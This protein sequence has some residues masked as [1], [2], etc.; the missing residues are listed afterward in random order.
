MGKTFSTGLLTNGIWQDASNNIGIGAAP[1]GTYKLEVTGT[2][3][4]SSTLLVSGA[5]TFSSSVNLGAIANSGDTSLLNIKQSSTAYN[6]GIYLERGGERNG[7]FMYI[8]G[9]VDSLTFRRNYFG[10]QSDVMSLTRDGN[11]G[12][13]TNSPT[14]PLH[15]ASNT[16][17]Q[18]NVAAL[19][20]NTN[21][22]INLEPTGTGVALIGPASA[23]PLTFRTDAIERMRITSGGIVQINGTNGAVRLTLQNSDNTGYMAF[24]EQDIRMWRPNGSGADFTIATQAISG[25]LGAGAIIFQPANVERMRITSAGQLY[26]SRTASSSTDVINIE[27]YS[28][29]SGRGIL[30]NM[31]AGNDAITIGGSGSQNAINVTNSSKKVI[32]S[33]LGG[34]GTVT[35]QADNSGT[36]I[37]S[38]DSTLKQEDKEYKIQGLAEILQLQPR[39]YKWLKDIEIRKEEAVT[40]IGFF[41]D[42]VNPIIPSAAPKGFDG[43][44]GFNDRA[45]TA[46]LVKGMQ[47]QQAQIQNLQEQNQ[48]LKSRLD[49]AG[50]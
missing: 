5:A 4:V 34:S 19:S 7:Y 37:K 3:K 47:E 12:I 1:N 24:T 41:A 9:A 23:F 36:L 33:N 15:I 20:G 39:A 42:E 48:D 31:D 6:N 44:Y 16:V 21:A 27:T 10:T 29:F 8:G 18:L 13:G 49:K 17:S 11:V 40:E 43:L 32:I 22:Q 38:S 28:G 45:V 30:L 26:F 50:L 25:T 35:V 46:A 2:A 14:N